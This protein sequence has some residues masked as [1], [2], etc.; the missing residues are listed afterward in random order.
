MKITEIKSNWK[1]S[2]LRI[3]FAL[4]NTCNFK[5]WYCFPG[6]NE[7][8][9]RWQDY[10]TIFPHFVHLV[11]HY[12]QAGKKKIYIQVVGGEPTLWPNF[13]NFAKAMADEG[14]IMSMA[15]NG[16][17]SLRWW[18]EN[19]QYFHRVILSCHHAEMD[20]EHTIQVADILYKAGC[21]VDA[22]VLM[23]PNVWD[24]C[25]G[26]IEQLKTSKHKW[27]IVAVEITHDTVSY[28][29]DQKQYLQQFMK[30]TP[31]LWYFFKN[32]KYHVDKIKVVTDELKTKSV[33]P[34]WIKLNN[35]NHFK[36]WNCNL[37]MDS[38]FIDNDGQI[39]GTC[40]ELLYGKKFYYNLYQP[41]FIKE[42]NP[43]LI[44]VTCTKQ[45]CHCQPEVNLRK[46]EGK[47]LLVEYP[48]NKYT[49]L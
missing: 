49:S 46:Q 35:L 4:G 26:I 45:S 7:G 19:A 8:T 39:R 25:V 23:D 38:I 24:K 32:N 29:D 30:R 1:D 34:T 11:R 13:A 40:G 5:C 22:N 9:H 10:N 41:N 14:C 20:I 2:E 18:T 17:R 47:P 37:G 3:E 21:I 44:P 48:L 36:G 6:S 27:S 16:S 42:F 43:E 15:T 12:K 28:T 33:T 31:N